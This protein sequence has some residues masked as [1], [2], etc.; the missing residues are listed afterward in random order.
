MRF[1]AKSILLL[2]FLTCVAGLAAEPKPV[3]K[4]GGLIQIK[5]R[6]VVTN[7]AQ[8]RTLSGP[9][10]FGGCNFKLTG[11]VTLLD[12]NR[13]LVVIQDLT[14]AVALHLCTQEG[15]LRV[16]LI[17]SIEGTNAV[18]YVASF[19]EYPH[20]PSS[21]AILRLFEAPAELGEYYLTRIRGYLHPTVT[22]E[23]TFWVASDNSSELWLSTDAHPRNKRKIASI[24][25]Y[26]WVEPR[27]WSR[28][29]SQR[30]ER[31][32]LK[33]GECYY[34]EAIHE[35]TTLASHL[36][37]AW[38]GPSVEPA[39]IGSEYL[40]PW[41]ED[42]DTTRDGRAA[43]IL[44]EYWTNFTAGD[45]EI[46]SDPRPF[47]S[48]LTVQHARVNVSG[49]AQM[50]EPAKLELGQR[51]RP[52]DNYRWVEVEGRVSFAGAD[53]SGA[54]LELTGAQGK[55]RVHVPNCGPA[56]LRGIQNAA[57]RV[58]GV[59]E[60][61]YDQNHV[62][63]PGLI[64][65]VGDEPITRIEYEGTTSRSSASDGPP[66][67][68]PA[69]PSRILSGF[70]GTRGVVTFNGR[71]LGNDF[72]FIQEGAAVVLVSLEGTG[73]KNDL[74]VGQ[75]LEAAG[76][77][78][79]GRHV[80]VLRP[81]VVRKVGWHAMPAPIAQ[82]VHVLPPE[83]SE[84]RWAE[85][86]GVVRRLNTDGTLLLV[87]RSG[88]MNVWVGRTDPNHLV[89][90][91]DARL[92]VRGV[93]CLTMFDSPLLL[94]PSLS[95]INVELDPP[96]DPFAIPL[97]PVAEVIEETALNAV[98]HRVRL[99]G[100]VTWADE[101]SFFLQDASGGVQVRPIGELHVRVGDQLEVV[102]FAEASR[103]GAVITEALVRS[104][105]NSRRVEPKKLD[106]R[107]PLAQ[108]QAGTLVFTLATLLGQK[109][110]EGVHVLQ[111]QEQQYVF[112]ATLPLDK[113][114]L[115]VMRPGSRLR[116]QGVCDYGAAGSIAQAKV[117]PEHPSASAL[118]ILLR[119]P[120]DVTLIKGPP[121]WT[122]GRIATLVGVLVGAV[123][124]VLAWVRL[125]HLRLERQQAARIAFARQFLQGQE[126]ERQRIAVNLHD[127]LGQSLVVIKN[128]ARLA[129]QS[130]PGDTALQQRLREISEVASQAVEEVRQIINDLRPYQLDRLGLTQAIRAIVSRASES[131]SILFAS[132]VDDMDG[133][134]DKDSE[135]HI[136][137]IVQEAVSNVLKHSQATEATVVVRS[138]PAKVSISVRDNG[139][140]FDPGTLDLPGTV[141]SGHG[142]TSIAERVRILGGT[143]RLN[144]HPGEGTR[145]DVEITKPSQLP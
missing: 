46:V 33:A 106:F 42:A 61:V 130:V 21:N 132:H 69:G 79:R 72:L 108:G 36:A 89:K 133:I 40:S 91:V 143:W 31:V 75:W 112:E 11:V 74:E 28:Y 51:L 98:A 93:L 7:V 77:L 66:E 5:P 1:V 57:V 128:Q 37:V 56:S 95:Y 71:V 70:Y 48:A 58:R 119:F 43:G 19:P 138:D 100:E 94:V 90:Y 18:P 144:S 117:G 124:S 102:G 142:L 92:R 2:V 14:G 141:R 82:P 83:D 63:I 110:N 113:G 45:L 88:R 52:E 49:S 39:V 96:D 20:H 107:D 55:A 115:A 16:G 62:L 12:T 134:F 126:A 121:W 78:E 87:G 10:W 123:V 38:E 41:I 81:L 64:W 111:L 27:E 44:W 129:M 59:C 15:P 137:R 25:R 80:P 22:G 116:I 73:L 65:A 120:S 30:S 99:L 131:S 34:I 105:P 118:T 50:P 9:D 29:P 54:L 86:E 23:Y 3:L 139:K 67:P 47:E 24:Q 35:Q 101:R 109:T 60:G 53:K 6:A 32:F 125:L 4:P 136:Y 127:S 13:D 135:I 85:I 26:H 114:D 8:F 140:G 17:V 84:G 145:L 68:A 104:S 97:V 103:A 122:P 76:A